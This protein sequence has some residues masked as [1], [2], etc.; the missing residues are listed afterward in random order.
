[1]YRNVDGI[2]TSCLGHSVRWRTTFGAFSGR[3][4]AELEIC[5]PRLPIFANP[6]VCVCSGSLGLVQ[7]IGKNSV[8]SHR[9]IWRPAVKPGARSGDRRTASR[10]MTEMPNRVQQRRLKPA[11]TGFVGR[12][13]RVRL[14]RKQNSGQPRPRRASAS[15]LQSGGRGRPDAL[16]TAHATPANAIVSDTIE[17]RPRCEAL[18]LVS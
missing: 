5:R 14:Q 11:A 12:R 1:M 13:W 16:R 18:S 2:A 7:P 9:L 3:M 6:A 10:A 4:S 15:R 8:R 17:A